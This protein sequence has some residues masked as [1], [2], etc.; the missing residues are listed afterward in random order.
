MNITTHFKLKTTQSKIDFIDVNLERDNE[1]FIDPRLIEISKSKFAKD[2][3]L[4]I[5]KFWGELILAIRQKRK[6]DAAYL[7]SGMKEPSETRLGY[8]EENS[9][10]KNISDKIRKNLLE[11]LE[12]NKAVRSGI[13]SDFADTELFVDD[14][15]CDRISDTTTKIIKQSLIDFTVEQCKLFKIRL[16]NLSQGDILNHKDLKWKNSQVSLPVYNDKP[17]LFVPKT[18]VRLANTSNN[19]IS[20]FYRYAIRNFISTDPTMLKDV[21]PTGKDGKLLLRDVKAAYP[22]SKGSLSKWVMKYGRLLVDFKSIHLKD[23][24]APATLKEIEGIV[25]G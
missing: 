7:L 19:N 12:K 8:A 11:V 22:V 15:G 21:S 3:K 20:S 5:G 9:Y 13:L 25:Y 14:I 4:Y 16:F 23:R 24:I 6:K 1:L 18:I 2:A 10:G 17:I